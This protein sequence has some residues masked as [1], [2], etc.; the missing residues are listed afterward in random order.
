MLSS[1]HHY[2]PGH[3]LDIRKAVYLSNFYP[4][5]ISVWSPITSCDPMFC[6]HIV[7]IIDISQ[8]VSVKLH[9]H[10]FP[11]CMMWGS[12]V[13]MAHITLP[14]AQYFCFAF[15]CTWTV[16]CHPWWLCFIKNQIFFTSQLRFGC[17]RY[18][19]HRNALPS[20]ILLWC[21]IRSPSF[22]EE[23]LDAFSDWSAAF[24]NWL[25]VIIK[26]VTTKMFCIFPQ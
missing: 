2:Q 14:P 15:L 25:V 10:F 11:L 22:S 17:S 9:K 18:Y 3:E 20:L 13:F 7:D 1:P 24:S 4:F 12:M 8:R 5:L 21:W 26:F 23:M 19:S 16:L 6:F